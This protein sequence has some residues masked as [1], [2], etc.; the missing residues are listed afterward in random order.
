LTALGLS[1]VL[2][3]LSFGLGYLR[4]ELG[5]TTF[6]IASAGSLVSKAV[7]VLIPIAF[8]FAI[9]KHRLLDIDILIRKTVVYTGVTGIVLVLYLTLAGFSGLVLVRLARLQ[10]EIA[11]VVATLAVVALFVPIRNRV[12]SF[13]DQRF[14][15]REHDLE[16]ARGRVSRLVLGS[17]DLE[18]LLPRLTE[19]TQQALH[20]RSVAVFV[21]SGGALRVEASVGF[22][23]ERA[24]PPAVDSTSAIFRAKSPVV[25]V[26]GL[27]LTED[28]HRAL[29]R[30]RASMVAI[31]RRDGEPVGLITVGKKIGGEAFDEEDES[32]LDSVADQLVLAMS[33]SYQTHSEAELHRA[34]EI[35]QSLL[36]VELPQISGVEVTARWQPAR[37]VG[38]DY[39]DVLRLADSRLALCI[40]DVVGKGMPAALLMSSLQA[41]LKAVAPQV[42]SPKE[43]CTRVRDVMLQSLAGGTFVTFFF[44]VIDRDAN[45]LSYTNAGH[46]PP[47]L[48]RADGTLVK[49]DIGGPILARIA[50]ETPYQEAAIA[51]DA[52]DRLVLYTDG[53]TEAMD[54]D[55]EMFEEERLEELILQ[56]RHRPV[57]ELEQVIAD[58]VLGHARGRLQDD[59][60]LVVASI[61]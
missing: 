29:R 27:D 1:I 48:V 3:V 44:C 19:E 18:D 43:V 50:A 58:T 33:R 2:M 5:A 12:Q 4:S 26:D 45:R 41:A 35:Q 10:G 17:R 53:V 9:L 52:G 60:T 37:E 31:A 25:A 11:T 7:S 36:P 39:F 15:R 51:V 49:L 32:F 42:A 13:V 22:P 38:G 59:L 24:A 14:F 20:S 57:R 54:A 21:R 55:E 6:V 40:G 16:D 23:D 46:N 34:R 30:V 47:M 56:H 61:L 28:D 8:A